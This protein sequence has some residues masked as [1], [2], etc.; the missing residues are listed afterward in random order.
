MTKKY[1]KMSNGQPKEKTL[2]NLMKIHPEFT[3]RELE[4]QY[5]KLCMKYH[6]DRQPNGS[7]KYYELC[8]A[9]TFLKDNYNR[10][11]YKNFGKWAYEMRE[12]PAKLYFFGRF[13]NKTNFALIKIFVVILLAL[14]YIVPAVFTVK[15]FKPDVPLLF[16]LQSLVFAASFLLCY[17]LIYT[18]KLIKNEIKTYIGYC[19]ISVQIL[20]RVILINALGILLVIKFD[21]RKDIGI[22]YMMLP[23]YIY[24]IAIILEE[25]ITVATKG[26][27]DIIDISKILFTI[28]TVC[29]SASIVSFMNLGV[30]FN[31]FII[32][33]LVY[34]YILFVRSDI[35]LFGRFCIASCLFLYS[36]GCLNLELLFI[37]FVL[38]FGLVLAV[39]VTTSAIYAIAVKLC[40]YVPKSDYCKYICLEYK[41]SIVQEYENSDVYFRDFD[42][43]DV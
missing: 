28:S 2:Y 32:S 26:C 5:Y 25:I 22:H 39:F 33:C 43:I 27:V 23:V 15:S 17:V 31:V 8:N 9:Y 20:I 41:S 11:L 7:E 13:L 6:P 37:T 4:R 16:I 38:K 24:T 3:E 10:D 12:D 1:S 29:L 34:M 42:I 19:L 35:Q 40:D 30:F 36:I 14:F 18:I 21:L